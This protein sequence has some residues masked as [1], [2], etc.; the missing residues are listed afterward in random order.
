MNS[1]NYASEGFVIGRI[2]FGEADRIITIF[3]KNFGKMSLI[4]KGVRRPMSK[5]RGSLEIFNHIKFSA[6]KSHGLDIITEVEP[7]D[8][9]ATIRKDIKKVSVAYYFC[10][11]IGRIA[12][13]EEKS[14]ASY[15]L[16]KRY[17]EELKI[18]NFKLKILRLNFV[19]EVL[20]AKGFWPHDKPMS[21]PDSVLENV[22]ERRINSVRVGKKMIQ[23]D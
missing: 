6:V 20:V 3:T 13:E 12:G 1:R 11:V 23:Q 7:L 10:E 2:R 4:A 21:D 17:L 16:F 5:K 18:L 9:Y 8:T 15:E 19:K 14:D 22:V